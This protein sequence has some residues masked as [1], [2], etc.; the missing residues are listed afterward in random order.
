MTVQNHYLERI[1]I[2]TERIAHIM[3]LIA[4]QDELEKTEE[5][6]SESNIPW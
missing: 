6:E 5:D 2:A 1:A 3:D 4:A